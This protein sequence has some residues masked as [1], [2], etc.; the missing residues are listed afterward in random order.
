ML[1]AA[2]PQQWVGQAGAVPPPAVVDAEHD[3]CQAWWPPQQKLVAHALQVAHHQLQDAP[4]G[5]VLQQE[6]MYVLLLCPGREKQPDLNEGPLMSES[7]IFFGRGERKAI[8]G[9]GRGQ[10]QKRACVLPLQGS[11]EV[12]LLASNPSSSPHQL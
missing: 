2:V 10:R 8:A 11:A 12:R 3:L 7:P 5:Q 4:I 6:R 9:A 1:V